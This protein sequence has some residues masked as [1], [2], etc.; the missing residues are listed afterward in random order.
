MAASC[1]NKHH[2]ETTP[3][4]QAQPEQH[5]NSSFN[6]LWDHLICKTGG[7]V[8]VVLCRNASGQIFMILSPPEHVF[9]HKKIALNCSMN[10]FC[11]LYHCWA[12]YA[13]AVTSCSF[14][15]PAAASE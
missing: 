10:D 15:W 12:T 6:L 5:G 8:L 1:I 3:S 4:I 13:D 7:G 2:F 14:I 9:R 11:L